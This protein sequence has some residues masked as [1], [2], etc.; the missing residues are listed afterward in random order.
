M[1]DRDCENCIHKINGAC[2]VWECKF[3]LK[4]GMTKEEAIEIIECGEISNRWGKDGE[5]VEEMAIKALKQKPSISEDGTLTVNVEDGSKVSRVLVCGDNHFGGVSY[6]DQEPCDKCVY[7]TSEG[8]QYDDITETIPPFDDCISRQAVL[9]A[10]NTDWHEDLSQLEDA[11]KALPPVEP[12]TGHW[13]PSHIQGSILDECSE[14][15]VSCGAF[16][17]KFCPMCGAKMVKEDKA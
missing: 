4:R 17:F 13:I 5:E 2:K 8:C 1:N 16:T 3:E 14:C 11:I 6:P 12:K 7:S 10:I 15:G 9:D